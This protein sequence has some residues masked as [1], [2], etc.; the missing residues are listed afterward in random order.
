M[1]GSPATAIPGTG[2]VPTP[3]VLLP[4]D[5]PAPLVVPYARRAEEL[6]FAELWVVEDLGFRG[7]VAQAAAALASTTTIRV[8]IGVLPTGARQVAFAAMELGTLAELFPGRVDAGVGHGMA[9]W[10]RSVGAW[11]ASPLTLLE[12]YTTALRSLLRGEEVTVDGRYVQLA[13]TRLESPPEVVPDVL[14]GVRGPRSLAVSGAVADGTV[15]AEPVTPEY[16][17][18]ALSDAAPRGR[19]RVV[20]YNAA[21]VDDDGAAAMAAV[22]PGLAWIGDADWAP[23][24]APLPF[25]AALAELRASTPDRDEFAARIPDAWV[26]RLAVT[27][28]PADARARLRDLAAAG[29]TSSVLIPVGPDPF[30]VLDRLSA[31]V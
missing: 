15:L 14:L 21:S 17:R 27:G 13:G 29:V 16:A 1:D 2:A 12:E 22:R 6:G 3:G 24:L 5:L 10:M 28:T 31:V 11:P 23:H 25:A 8:G 26:A 4:R 18:A 30:V 19:H 9:G 7:G 20:A